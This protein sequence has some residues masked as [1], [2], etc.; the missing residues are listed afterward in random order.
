MFRTE[1]F[2]VQNTDIS[3]IFKGQPIKTL[4]S[5]TQAT[6][7]NKTQYVIHDSKR[8][9]DDDPRRVETCSQPA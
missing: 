5:K 6:K 7:I 4:D 8:R 9:P 3:Q 1:W 2:I